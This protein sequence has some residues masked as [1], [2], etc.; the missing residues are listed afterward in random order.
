M[1]DATRNAHK[2]ADASLMP[3]VVGANVN[4]NG[5]MIGEKASDM[6]LEAQ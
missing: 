2:R 6:I 5:I 3:F 1:V 4:G